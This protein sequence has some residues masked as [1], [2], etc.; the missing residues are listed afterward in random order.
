MKCLH[1]GTEMLLGGDHDA[2][3]EEYETYVIFTNFSCQK[4][5]S[6]AVFYSSKKGLEGS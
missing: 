4:C 3:V 6:F 5:D 1:C 2:E